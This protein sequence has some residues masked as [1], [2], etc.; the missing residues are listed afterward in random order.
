MPVLL[1]EVLHLLHASDGGRFI[2]CTVGA[3]GHA[4]S[5]LSA[6]GG[7]LLGLDS[8]SMILEKASSRLEVYGEACVLRQG[9]FEEIAKIAEDTGFTGVDGVLMDLGVSSLQLDTPERGFSFMRDGPLDMRMDRSLKV[10]A[11]D[12]VNGLEMSELKT[13]IKDYGEEPMAGSIASV[14][15]RERAKEPI[16]TTS[17]LADLVRISGKSRDSRVHPATKTFQALRIAV[18]RELEVLAG[19]LAGAYSVLRKGGR[20]AV[21]SYHSL[22]DRI[23][24]HFFRKHVGFHRSLESG[25]S[26]WI[27]EKPAGRLVNKKIIKPTELEVKKNFRSRS[28]K[29]RVIERVE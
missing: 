10:S 26:E 1:N 17:R 21:I 20:L 24:K 28:A 19:G 18:N 12:L 4:E 2:D 9:N 5:L 11:A 14:I 13:I 8:D 3:G 25:G 15:V 23:V 27:G 6:S 16:L 29:L 7:K 22:E